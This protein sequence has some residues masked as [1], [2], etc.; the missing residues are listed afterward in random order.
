MDGK[1]RVSQQQFVYIGDLLVA[2]DARSCARL[3][4][5]RCGAEGT[6]RLMNKPH[7]H[8]CGVLM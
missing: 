5:A 7:V 1:V 8:S 4:K 6:L 2:G 3:K